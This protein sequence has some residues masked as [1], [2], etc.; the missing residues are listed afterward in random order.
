MLLCDSCDRGYDVP[1]AAAARRAGGQLVLSECSSGRAVAAPRLFEVESI[2]PPPLA[3]GGGE[4]EYL[5]R[6]KGYGPESDSYEPRSALKKLQALATTRRSRP[7]PSAR[8][9]T[10]PPPCGP[11]PP[12][13]PPPSARGRRRRRGRAS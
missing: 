5:V 3:R 10:T 7:P 4:V 8:A 11:T 6:W 9:R 12:P 13:R 2:L 1:H